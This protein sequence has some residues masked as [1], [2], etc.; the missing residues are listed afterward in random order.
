MS[1]TNWNLLTS[2]NKPVSIAGVHPLVVQLLHNRGITDPSQIELFLS[3]DKRVETDPFLLPDMDRAVNR[4]YQAL[5][6]GEKIAIYGD[7]DA[8]GVTATA[9]LVQGITE[10]GGTVIPYIPR[11]TADGYGLR[12]SAIEKLQHQGVSL[13][14][15]VDTGITAIPEIEKA[16]KAGLDIVVTDHHVPL[17]TLPRARAVID[18]KR[19]DS[20]YPYSDL[21]GVGVAFK[22]LQALAKGN[23][24]EKITKKLLDLVAL[25]TITDMVP[26]IGESRYWVKSGLDL[27]NKTQR[28]GLQELIRR[29]NLQPGHL[30]EQSIGWIIGPRINAA[31][32]MDD[33]TTSYQLLLTS[34]TQEAI[35]LAMELESKN[36]ERVKKTNESMTKANEALIAEGVE[37]PLLIT[38]N[39]DIPPGVLGLVAGRLTDRYYR[40]V[41]ILKIGKE[42]CRGSC[43]SISEF[44]II[45]ALE[46]CQDLLTKFGGHTRAAGFNVPT[47]NLDEFKK[48]I[49][50]IAGTQLDGIDLRPHVNI[51]AE[52]NLSIF[53]GNTFE[54]IQQLA[55][56][57][58]G[59]PLPTFISRRV[60]VVDQRLIGSQGEH[61]RLKLKQGG[62][63][64]DAMGFNLGGYAGELAPYIDIV[65]N[66]ELDRWNGEERLRLTIQD[67]SAAQ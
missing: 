50:N 8:D 54:Q 45:A 28:L 66:I 63:I 22:L 51:D 15:T 14:I 6:S 59:N 23:G 47:S 16:R 61:L 46:E 58:I 43:R 24:R 27:I 11:R 67:F 42:T 13:I 25:G 40:P 33:A 53:S 49:C 60:S 5:F 64:W 4:I 39:E 30:D 19:N 37:R 9:L 38:G 10:L 12:T 48:R 3:N 31:G 57:G 36:A 52:V 2:L 17:G 32:R 62:I 41:I 44:D 1:H 21:A 20:P 29:T 26:L 35:A 65:Y 7:F 34:D 18:P 55:P 56:F